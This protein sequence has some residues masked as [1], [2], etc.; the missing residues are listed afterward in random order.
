MV[1]NIQNYWVLGLPSSSGI[2][3]T[4]KHDVSETGSVSVLK[5]EPVIRWLRLAL[6]KGPNRVGVPP[7]TE[8]GNRSSFWNL[9]FPSFKNTRRWT[10][11]KTPSNSEQ[12]K[13][14]DKITS[15]WR[16]TTHRYSVKEKEVLVGHSMLNKLLKCSSQKDDNYQII[17]SPAFC[18]IPKLIT[19]ITTAISWASW[20]HS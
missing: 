13:S 5:W 1:Y 20:V 9:M 10:R 19:V 4:R 7:L 12:W 3:W 8:D 14:N 17:K 11:S 2:L 15:H 6:S 18:G 16:S